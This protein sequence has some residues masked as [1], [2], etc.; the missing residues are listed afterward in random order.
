MFVYMD[1][2]VYLYECV[3]IMGK[4]IFYTLVQV[5]VGSIVIFILN[6]RQ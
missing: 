6:L 3:C 4:G 1:V 5:E 2:T